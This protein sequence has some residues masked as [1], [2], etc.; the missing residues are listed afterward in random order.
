MGNE[1]FAVF[2]TIGLTGGFAFFMLLLWNLA[3]SLKSYIVRS[4]GK[5]VWKFK[6]SNVLKG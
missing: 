5:E 1:V 2:A 6:R 4:R 3:M